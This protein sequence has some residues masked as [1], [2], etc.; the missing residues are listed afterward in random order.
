MTPANCLRIGQ[1]SI[2]TVHAACPMTGCFTAGCFPVKTVEKV[3]N[4]YDNSTGNACQF[5]AQIAD[6]GEIMD[7]LQKLIIIVTVVLVVSGLIWFIVQ[8]H[9]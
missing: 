3:A 4:L 1:P 9:Q 2:S 7:T 6:I 5:L 8:T